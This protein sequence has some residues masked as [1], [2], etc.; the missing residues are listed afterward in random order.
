M[1]RLVLILLAVVAVAFT[2][3]QKET[4][5]QVV[6]KSGANIT[7]VT[8]WQ[9]NSNGDLIGSENIGNLT[10]GSKSQIVTTLDAATS[11][12]ISFRNGSDM[13]YTGHNDLIDGRKNVVEITSTTPTTGNL[14]D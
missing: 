6:N 2:S 7:E 3:C 4:A 11:V 9:F 5:C 8:I 14:Y 10:D 1:K 13:K 12:K